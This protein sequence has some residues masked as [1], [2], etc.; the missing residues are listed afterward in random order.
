ME[1]DELKELIIGKVSQLE[2]QINKLFDKIDKDNSNSL[3]K[4]EIKVYLKPIIGCDDEE[5]DDYITNQF[6]ESSLSR[7][8][9]RLT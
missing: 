1:R 9:F 8:D 3:E 7:D 5:L 4:Q 6:G 2:L